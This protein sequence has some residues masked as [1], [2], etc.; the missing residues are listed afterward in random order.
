MAENENVLKPENIAEQP[1][2]EQPVVSEAVELPAETA[3]KQPTP[4]KG[5][6]G[7]A[8]KEWFRKQIVA[9]KR[10][11]QNITLLFLAVTTIY[12]MLAL[13]KISQAIYE[14]YSQEGVETTI[15]IFIFVTTLLSLLV[16]VSFLNSFPKR[17]KP[18]IFFIV[19]V[20]LMIGAMIA[21]DIVYY[22]QMTDILSLPKLQGAVETIAKVNI[23]QTYIIVHVAL[24]GVSAVV[25]ALLPVYAKLI[26][27][28]N[29][30]VELESATEN[31]RGAID[32]QED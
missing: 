6:K 1:V 8:V 9:L 5:K 12:F 20:F 27:K 30:K 22:V 3:V 31:M 2:E 32:I 26:N 19:L 18:N 29:T 4:P 21:C 11:P 24:L 14:V 17:K 23:G 13:F 25:F 7:G 16:L 15:G 28:I 10:K